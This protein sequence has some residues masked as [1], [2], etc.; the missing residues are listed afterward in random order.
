MVFPLG[1]YAAGSASYGQ[2]TNLSFMV[3]IASVELWVAVAVWAGVLVAMTRSLLPRRHLPE[4]A[5]P[6]ATG[7]WPR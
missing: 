3:D 1:M 5:P 6:A 2:A 4:P 7:P